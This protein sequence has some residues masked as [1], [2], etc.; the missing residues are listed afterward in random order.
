MKYLFG[1]LLR[2]VRPE[3]IC[4]YALLAL[5]FDYVLAHNLKQHQNTVLVYQTGGIITREL[6]IVKKSRFFLF[7]SQKTGS[8]ANYGF[9]C[10][11]SRWENLL[12]IGPHPNFNAVEIDFVVNKSVC[13]YSFKLCMIRSYY[14]PFTFFF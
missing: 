5:A 7:A 9:C 3:A 12:E 8:F 4:M 2:S 14:C 13:K 10:L 1:L 6:Q 11:I